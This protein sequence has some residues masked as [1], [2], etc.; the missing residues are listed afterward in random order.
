MYLNCKTNEL[1]LTQAILDLP[2]DTF[3]LF[4]DKLQKYDCTLDDTGNDK[5]RQ[6]YKFVILVNSLFTIDKKNNS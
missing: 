6:E 2:I 5:T 1:S 3:E 4:H